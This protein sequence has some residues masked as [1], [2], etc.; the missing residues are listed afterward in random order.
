VRA[1]HDPGWLRQRVTIEQVTLAP[2]DAGGGAE[3]WT[4][5]ATVWARIEPLNARE[6]AVADHQATGITHRITIRFRDGIAGGQRVAYRGR[7]FR[8]A[9]AADP[10]EARRYLELACREE[11]P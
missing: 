9:A 10:D 3:T 8:I 2:D 7:I 4:A 5:L 11:A 1:G 6:L